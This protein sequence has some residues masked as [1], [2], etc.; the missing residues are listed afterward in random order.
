MSRCDKLLRKARIAPGGL[1]YEEICR[2][3]ECHGFV[4]RRQRGSHRIY[5]HPDVPPSL[6]GHMNFQNDNG[7]AKDY[8]VRQLR[9]AIDF[10]G[11]N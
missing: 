7:K 11:G 4:F 6:G 9:D 8:Q 1:S 2:L 3:A 10:L 5:A